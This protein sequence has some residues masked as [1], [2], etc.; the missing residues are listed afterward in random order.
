MSVLI[1]LTAS[2]LAASV[3]QEL[4]KCSEG[5]RQGLGPMCK[6]VTHL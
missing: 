1:D 4:R 6:A 2:H 5:E 3:P